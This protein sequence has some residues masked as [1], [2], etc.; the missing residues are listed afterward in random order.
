MGFNLV[1][2]GLI[3]LDGCVLNISIERTDTV[4]MER[5]NHMSSEL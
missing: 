5:R 2:K 3:R 4:N 1:F